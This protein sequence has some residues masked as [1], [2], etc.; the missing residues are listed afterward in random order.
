MPFTIPGTQI[1]IPDNVDPTQYILSLGQRA[2]QQLAGSGSAAAAPAT[3]A[4]AAAPDTSARQQLVD[5]LAAKHKGQIGTPSPATT[6]IKIPANAK[7]PDGSPDPDAGKTVQQATGYDT[8]TFGDGTSI[9]FMPD[10][11][12]RNLKIGP[13]SATGKTA[14]DIMAES[15]QILGPN[16]QVYVKNPDT[17]PGAPPYILDTNSQNN[18]QIETAKSVAAT[19][20]SQAQAALNNADAQLKLNPTNVALQQA[21]DAAQAKLTSAQADAATLNAASTANRVGAQN[22]L[23]TAQAG[24]ATQNAATAAQNAQSTAQ[25]VLAQNALDTAQARSANTSADVA[26]GRLPSQIALDTAQAN[27]Q[28]AAATAALQKANEPTPW[29]PNTTAPS[30]Q[31][32]DPTTGKVVTNQ[33]PNYLPTDPGRMTAQLKQQADAQWQALQQQVQSGKL[34][35][36][37]AASQ[38]DK[39][40]S[41]SIEPVKGDIAAAQA[42]QQ[43]AIDLQQSQ[44]GLYQAQAANYPAALAQT[45]S[46]D[47]QK[48]LIS[49]LPYVVGAG[50]ATTPGVTAGKGGF[51]Q[52]NPQQIMQNA[53]Y[54]L[55]NLQ[56]IGRQGAAA[57]L[58]NFSPTA[59]MHAQMPGPPGQPPMPGLPDLNSLL[60]QSSYGGAPQ[61]GAPP[62]QAQPAPGAQ[63]APAAAGGAPAA[64]GPQ[65]DWVSVMARLNQDRADQSRQAQMGPIQP[66]TP[67]LYN[68]YYQQSAVPAAGMPATGPIAGAITPYPAAGGPA[69]NPLT[70][71]SVPWGWPPYQPSS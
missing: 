27:S 18:Q 51:P 60:N 65:Q 39:Y 28:N 67:G 50:A 9:E 6:S 48:N 2:G 52:I 7:L 63:P 49:M 31:Y 56:E 57:A 47:A 26:A 45:A 19:N 14:S 29:S 59:A 5:A 1:T 3:A 69:P 17:S 32:Y 37:Q 15:G 13:G 11:T 8:Y 24:A 22:T 42:K 20:A 71:A 61:Q 40:W 62:A 4:T 46:S 68:P 38:F 35:G 41:E 10:G 33:N 44:S 70:G 21:K 34:T 30:Q 53:T 58:A 25:R 23:D 66:P 43:A 12:S 36:D 55:P 54:S 64:G 16:G